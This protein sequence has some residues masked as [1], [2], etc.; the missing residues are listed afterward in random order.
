MLDFEGPG[1]N[2][3]VGRKGIAGGDKG[4]VRMN[5]VLSARNRIE[6]VRTRKVAPS[7]VTVYAGSV[8]TP[9]ESDLQ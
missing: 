1:R 9:L 2:V 4:K 8:L 3:R 6:R 7:R 5:Q